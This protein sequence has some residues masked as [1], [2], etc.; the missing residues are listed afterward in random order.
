MNKKH[1]KNKNGIRYEEDLYYYV[2]IRKKNKKSFEKFLEL[3]D[4]FMS[5]NIFDSEELKTGKIKFKHT[6][7]FESYISNNSKELSMILDILKSFDSLNLNYIKNIIVSYLINFNK[8]WTMISK[9][10]SKSGLMDMLIGVMNGKDIIVKAT[11]E[12]AIKTY[13]LFKGQNLKNKMEFIDEAYDDFNQYFDLVVNKEFIPAE[14]I[15][16]ISKLM[17]NKNFTIPSDVIDEKDPVLALLKYTADF[18]NYTEFHNLTVK[19]NR[20]LQAIKKSEEATNNH[21]K[22]P[23]SNESKVDSKK[24]PVIDRE[25]IIFENDEASFFNKEEVDNMVKSFLPG[26]CAEDRCCVE[27]DMLPSKYDPNYNDIIIGLLKAYEE[28]TSNLERCTMKD[29]N[30]YNDLLIMVEQIKGK[31]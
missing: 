12:F 31:S 9:I 1:E 19:K 30:K 14:L 24:K 22:I 26:I 4:S 11:F 5:K 23:V 27:D 21:K 6:E 28:Y 7:Q 16:R 13:I 2:K 8:T 29:F 3:Y 17:M 15:D 10:D 25:T 18:A 20:E